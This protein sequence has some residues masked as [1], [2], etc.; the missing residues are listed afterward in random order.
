[1]LSLSGDRRKALWGAIREENKLALSCH[2][3]ELIGP[4]RPL[5]KRSEVALQVLV[6]ALE[7]LMGRP[8]KPIISWLFIGL[9]GLPIDSDLSESP[10]CGNLRA[11]LPHVL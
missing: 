2:P 3:R 11:V 10:L 1:M 6:G 5:N 4:P 7:G 8:C 9:Q